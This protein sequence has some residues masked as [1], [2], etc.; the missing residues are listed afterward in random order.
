M[1]TYVF[2]IDGT[3]C[4]NVDGVYKNS[5]PLQERIDEINKLFESY[6]DK[7]DSTSEFRD[8]PYTKDKVR[9]FTFTNNPTPPNTDTEKIQ[10]LY[11]GNNEGDLTKWNN[12]VKLQ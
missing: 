9:E 2:D 12:K 6:N 11:S 7:V 5:E 3:I 8:I 4:T 1:K 10:K